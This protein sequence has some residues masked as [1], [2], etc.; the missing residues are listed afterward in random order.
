MLGRIMLHDILLHQATMGVVACNLAWLKSHLHFVNMAIPGTVKYL[1]Q[2]SLPCQSKLP[3]AG[4]QGS[5][6]PGNS[7][8]CWPQPMNAADN[9][10]RCHVHLRAET[11]LTPICFSK[12]ASGPF[13]AMPG[14]GLA[15]SSPPPRVHR[16]QTHCHGKEPHGRS[17]KRR[18]AAAG[19]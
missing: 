9:P 10:H 8:Y 1:Q 3:G 11:S 12:L 16:M 4:H 6:S 5:H 15:S 17:T 19:R 14:L 18:S 13:R 2:G 7:L